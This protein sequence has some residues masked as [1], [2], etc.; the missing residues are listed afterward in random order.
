MTKPESLIL[1]MEYI[2]LE[3]ARQAKKKTLELLKN[4]PEVSAIGISR[5]KRFPKKGYSVEI[6]LSQKLPGDFYLPKQ[7]YGVTLYSTIIG[8]IKFI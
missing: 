4:R 2:N 6:R 1:N 3:Q 5:N 7:I 8:D